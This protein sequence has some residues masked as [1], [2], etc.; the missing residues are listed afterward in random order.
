M[1]SK[2]FKREEFACKCCSCSFNAVDA[3]LLA[4]LED[5]RSFFNKPVV[6][7]SGN[8]CFNHNKQVGG[9]RYS[10]HLNGTACD[11]KVM[12]VH[13]DD[14]ADYLEQTYADKYGIGRYDGRT[15]IDTREIIA[16]WDSRIRVV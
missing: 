13:A 8:R 1:I 7:T 10:Q 2:N 15:H 14:V 12:D 11:F 4:I 16:R 9:A 6:I 5:V 3:E